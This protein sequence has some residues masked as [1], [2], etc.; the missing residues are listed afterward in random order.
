MR[1]Q[2]QLKGEAENAAPTNRDYQITPSLFV[3][4]CLFIFCCTD[5][6]TADLEKFIPSVY[7]SNFLSNVQNLFVLFVFFPSVLYLESQL[8][9]FFVTVC[10]SVGILTVAVFLCHLLD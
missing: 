6:W 3:C 8:W 5:W 10:T 2:E 1:R 4:F 9:Y 7:F